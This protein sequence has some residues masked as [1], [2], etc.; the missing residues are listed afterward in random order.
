MAAIEYQGEPESVG[1]ANLCSNPIYKTP[2]DVIKETKQFRVDLDAIL[3]K[4]QGCPRR[5]EERVYALKALKESIMWLGM[6]LKDLGT[7]NPYP[8]SY[9]PENAIVDPTAD[10]LK[11]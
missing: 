6:D 7:P 3:Q 4:M 8:N 11:L 2:N 5:S 1:S 10:G 9:K